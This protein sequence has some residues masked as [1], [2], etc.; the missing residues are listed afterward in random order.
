MKLKE[1]GFVK[2][3]LAAD[4]NILIAKAAKRRREEGEETA[5]FHG[6]VEIKPAKFENFKSERLGKLLTFSLQV[7][8]I[9]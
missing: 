2:Y 6:S 7:I 5:F 8:G 3:L 9:A 1:C 4:M